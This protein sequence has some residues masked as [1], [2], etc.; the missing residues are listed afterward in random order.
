MIEPGRRPGVHR[1]ARVT[2]TA[3]GRLVQHASTSTRRRPAGRTGPYA[4]APAWPPAGLKIRDTPGLTRGGSGT[5]G[6]RSTTTRPKTRGRNQHHHPAPQH[7][8]P[9]QRGRQLRRRI[10]FPRMSRQT[11]RG[12]GSVLTLTPAMVVSRTLKGTGKPTAI[13]APRRPLTR[14][15][16]KCFAPPTLPAVTSG[17]TSGNRFASNWSSRVDQKSVKWASRGR[18]L[19]DQI[20]ISVFRQPKREDGNLSAGVHS[21]VQTQ[22]T[23]MA[24]YQ[25]RHYLKPQKRTETWEMKK[26]I[27]VSKQDGN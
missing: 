13:Q 4:L 22:T 20:G 12:V 21:R 8:R 1:M 23:R 10:L 18:K 27:V 5:G 3:L 9:P 19:S 11:A 25:C 2:A 24:D 16:A 14:R 6:S 15:R 26:I 7:A 17:K